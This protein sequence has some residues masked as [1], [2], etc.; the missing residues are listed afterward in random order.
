MK[1]K[2]RM[3]GCLCGKDEKDIRSSQKRESKK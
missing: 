1:G 3:G 2:E